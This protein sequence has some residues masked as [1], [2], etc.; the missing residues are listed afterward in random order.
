MPDLKCG[1]FE[2]KNPAQTLFAIEKALNILKDGRTTEID[3]PNYIVKGRVFKIQNTER[4]AISILIM[5][6]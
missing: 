1:K 2:I 5:E 6:P 4:R 3:T